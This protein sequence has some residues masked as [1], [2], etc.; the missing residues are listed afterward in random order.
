MYK[1]NFVLTAVLLIALVSGAVAQEKVHWDVVQ[2]IRDEGFNNS[3]VME[4][5]EI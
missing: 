2:K 3:Q 4:I 5:S 1:K